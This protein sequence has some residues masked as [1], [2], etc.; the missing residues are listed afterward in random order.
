METILVCP[1]CDTTVFRAKSDGSIYCNNC[2]MTFMF[3]ESQWVVFSPGNNS[4]V[5]SRKNL[6][7]AYDQS[8]GNEEEDGVTED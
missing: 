5:F 1:E 6:K 8:L 7:K 2:S 4:N 3:H